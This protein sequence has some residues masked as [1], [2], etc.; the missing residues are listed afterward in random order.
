MGWVKGVVGGYNNTSTGHSKTKMLEGFPTSVAVAAVGSP[1]QHVQVTF[2]FSSSM[3]IHPFAR[4][5]YSQGGGDGTPRADRV[6]VVYTE[7]S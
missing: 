3:G 5:K 4:F 6:S 2:T 7:G 1:P